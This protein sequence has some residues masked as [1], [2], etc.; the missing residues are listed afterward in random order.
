MPTPFYHL[1]MAEHL[2]Q[3]PSLPGELRQLFETQRPAYYLGHT[4]P[5]VQVVSGQR[6]EDTHFYSIPLP[7]AA[8][9]PW[10]RFFVELPE[11]A[12]PSQLSSA[13]VAF[14]AGYLCH[15]QADWIWLKQVF[16]PVFGPRA[17]WQTLP[18]RLYLHN[19]LRSYLDFQ[20]LQSLN[21]ITRTSLERVSPRGW[22]PFVEDEHLRAWLHLL[23]V[24][25]KPGAA[26]QTVEVFAARQGIDTEEFYRLL[27]SEPEMDRRIFTHLPRY[28]LD[29]YRRLVMD[30]NV[31]LLKTYLEHC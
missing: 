25:L 31:S 19:V 27:R 30:E 13:Q 2:L 5:D 10:E 21:G 4:A 26:I 16:L 18:E 14:L 7:S 17:K 1:S 20:I 9:V 3:H 15:L 28:K 11:L 29:D 23:S 6:R 8:M 22:L 12:V 24:Q